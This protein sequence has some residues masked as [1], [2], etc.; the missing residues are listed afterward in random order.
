[1]LCIL[2]ENTVHAM[3]DIERKKMLGRRLV[4]ARRGQRLSQ[5]R[6][7]DI[8]GVAR[9][10]LVSWEDGEASPS[11]IQLG[12]IAMTYGVCAHALL[13]GAPWMPFDIAAMV[14]PR[15]AS[16]SAKR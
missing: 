7:A 10:E 6:A 8:V 12:C 5:Q 15:V 3:E 9:G 1:M 16:E 2:W 13:F 11:A 4:E 14:R